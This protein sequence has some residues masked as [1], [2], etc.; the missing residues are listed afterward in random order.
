MTESL[1][2]KSF[3]KL[4]MKDFLA[5]K[6]LGLEIYNTR[7]D[8]KLHFSWLRDVVFVTSTKHVKLFI[9]EHVK[10]FSV[11]LDK[12]TVQRNSYSYYELFLL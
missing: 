1:G 10:Y 3:V 6:D 2:S 4:N 8:S 9:E 5:E 12:V 11:T 7:N